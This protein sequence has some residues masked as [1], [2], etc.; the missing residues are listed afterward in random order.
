MALDIKGTYVDYVAQ[1]NRTIGQKSD[2]T[3]DGQVV[4]K[5]DRARIGTLPQIGSTHPDDSRLKQFQRNITYAPNSEVIMTASYFGLTLSKTAETISYSGGQNNDPIETHP[6]F[7]SFAGTQGAPLNGA[8][9]D[10]DTG[11]FIGFIS[12][13]YQGVQYYLTAATVISLS[14]W[15]DSPPVLK[16]RMSIVASL[17]GFVTPPDVVNFLLLDSPYRQIGTWYYQVTE[18]YLGSG[19]KGWDPIIYPAT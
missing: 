17:P 14:Y 6:D 15:T 1:P 19:V 4:F 3:L 2:G 7:E 12:G 8:V 18:Q 13:D 5:T 10:D 16:N 11:E 9:F